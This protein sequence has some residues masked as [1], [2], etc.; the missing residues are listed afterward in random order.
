MEKTTMMKV[1]YF[2]ADGN[3]V[4]VECGFKPQFV[5]LVNLTD[6][7]Y[8][9]LFGDQECVKGTMTGGEALAADSDAISTYDSASF[10]ETSSV[11]SA[12]GYQGFTVNS[13]IMSDDDLCYYF[14]VGNIFE[15]DHGDQA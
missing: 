1:G 4:N 2:K 10:S 6:Q 8:W 11:V 13:D 9:I 15:E 3:A 5:Y 14:A 12:S 7:L